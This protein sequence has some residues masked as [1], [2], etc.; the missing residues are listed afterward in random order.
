MENEDLKQILKCSQDPIYFMR[1]FVKTQH[2]EKGKT[3]F[4]DYQYLNDLINVLINESR[5]VVLKSRQMMIT[6]TAVA[7]SLWEAIFLGNKDIMFISKREDDAKEAIHRLNYILD[8]LPDFMIPRTGE[9]SKY[10]VEFP[11][12]RSRLMALPTTP[13]IGR[14]YSP[15]RIIWDEMAS[16][17]NDEDVFTALQPSL[18]GGGYF[19][20]ISTSQGSMT[21]HAELF[22]NAESYG[23]KKL[24]IHYSLHPEKDENWKKLACRGMSDERWK[25]EQEM[26]LELGGKRIYSSFQKQ[27]H[28]IDNID[29]DTP[30][31]YYRTIDFGYHTPVV[32]WAKMVNNKI[33]IFKEWIGKDSTISDI[34]KATIG[35]D[36]I[37]GLTED[38]FERTFCDPAGAAQTDRGIS[39][40]DRLKQE[41]LEQTGI[42]L[43]ITY[44]NSSV[45]AGIDLVREKLR[46]AS[47]EI[48]LFVS[49][50]CLRTVSDFCR[51]IKKA[52]SNEPKK[53]GLAEHTMDA[54]RY[55]MVNLYQK[56]KKTG[57]GL[58]RPK[59]SVT[60]RY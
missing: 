28:V 17:P 34:T 23:F 58:L 42:E 60:D 47:G 39:S 12:L 1:N 32:L 10:V 35:T 2:R 18:D 27:T 44:R 7:F 50:S 36:E 24:S 56:N 5:V 59:I 53:D 38:D 31:R 25:M 13:N 54:V 20:G 30:G 16:T 57:K 41:Y 48:S 22:L 37:L 26:S 15:T 9:N 3:S 8:N 11:G 33:V 4:P 55:L 19:V 45:M 52:G 51:Y 46:N 40:V 43:K 6:W 21:K 29:P 49:S 14:T